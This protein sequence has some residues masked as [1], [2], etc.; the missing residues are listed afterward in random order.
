MIKNILSFSLVSAALWCSTAAA[1]ETSQDDQTPA[2]TPQTEAASDLDLGETGPRVG[3]QYVKEESGDWE[4]RCLKTEAGKDPCLLR[5]TL[6]GQEGQPIAEISVNKLPEGVAAVAGATVIVPLEIMLQAQLALSIDG[7]PGKRYDYHHCNPIGCVAQLGFT[8]GDVDAM[9]AG[10]TA[11]MSVV[12]V[13]APNQLLEIE[14]SLAG[15]TA[16]FDKL[17]IN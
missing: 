16:G 7:A 12:S 9:K 13:L 15:F 4:I 14:I 2:E 3:E 6:S 5:Q 11:K 8:Q 1:Q 17:E 10:S